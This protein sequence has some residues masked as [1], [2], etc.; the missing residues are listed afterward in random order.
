MT[1]ENDDVVTETGPVYDDGIKAL[2]DLVK[3]IAPDAQKCIDEKNKSAGRRARKGLLELG[4]LV[5]PLR[6]RL[7]DVTSPKTE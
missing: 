5:K 1:D 4:K 7:S 3:Q 2:F 6:K